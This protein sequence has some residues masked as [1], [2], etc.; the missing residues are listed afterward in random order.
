MRWNV[1]DIWRNGDVWILGGGPSIQEQFNI[2][3]ALVDK[4][5]H[6]IESPASYS[7]YMGD[8]HNKHVIGINMAYLLGTW[9]DLIFF[10]DNGFFDNNKKELQKFPG[11]LISCATKTDEV[12]W[13]KYL[14]KDPRKKDGITT[15]KNMVAWNM[16][17]GAA[18]IS[19]AV[20]TGAKRIFLLG[21]DMSLEN[22]RQHWHNQ[23][24]LPEKKNS[25]KLPFHKHIK[26]FPAIAKDAKALGI[27]IYNVSPKS[28]IIE[29]PKITLKEAL[30]L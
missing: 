16:N 28:K 4:V 18:A 25:A 15:N 26:G 23:Y 14:E 21:F 29:F 17:S 11:L 30:S 20:H 19:L 6:S 10:G 22:N 3:D 8:I 7:S 9:I 13:V 5:F 12:S 1:P 24:N 2:P 27:E